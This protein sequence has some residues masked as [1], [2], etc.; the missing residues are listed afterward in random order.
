MNQIVLLLIFL[1][2][3]HAFFSTGVL[4]QTASHVSCR[5]YYCYKLHIRQSNRS[6]LL[7]SA[8]L[9][10]Q[11]VVDMYIELETT[12]L[13]YYRKSQANLRCELYQGIVDSVTAGE[14]RASEVGKRKILSGSHVGGPR[15]MRRRYLNAMALVQ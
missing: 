15:D 4:R 8:R 1:F 6:I 9:L 12:K 5:E 10:Q 3:S 11:F 14:T 2:V 13:D 7:R